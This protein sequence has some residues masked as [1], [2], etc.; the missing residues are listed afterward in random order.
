MKDVVDEYNKHQAK[1]I[2]TKAAYKYL[3][4]LLTIGYADKKRDDERS[5]EEGGDAR[6]NIYHTIERKESFYSRQ[7]NISRATLS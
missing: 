4:N 2:S 1:K 7:G 3:E 6:R 5:I